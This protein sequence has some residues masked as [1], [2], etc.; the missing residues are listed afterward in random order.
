MK[1]TRTLSVLTAAAVMLSQ[2][3]AVGVNAYEYKP[4]VTVQDDSAQFA[5]LMWTE[6]EDGTLTIN[7]CV[8][9]TS[10]FVG[11]Y[12]TTNVL[13]V[14]VYK[15]VLPIPSEING[16]AVTAIKGVNITKGLDIRYVKVYEDIED[17]SD[18]AFADDVYIVTTDKEYRAANRR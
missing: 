1:I 3:S 2:A 16:K 18:K 17:I 9:F 11:D 5:V 6:N 10:P 14:F 4:T 12:P 8:P 7:G 15:G 13:S